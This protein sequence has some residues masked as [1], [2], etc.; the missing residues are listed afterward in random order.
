[1]DDDQ[2]RRYELVHLSYEKGVSSASWVYGVS[3]QNIYKWRRRYKEQGIEGLKT[4]SRAHKSY[5]NKISITERAE[6]IKFIKLNPNMTF[7]Q[8]KEG[9]KAKGI[10]RHWMTIYKIA[11][12]EGYPKKELKKDKYQLV[13]GTKPIPGDVRETE[14]TKATKGISQKEKIKKQKGEVQVQFMNW[15]DKNKYM[16]SK[17][18][19]KKV[20]YRKINFSSLSHEV[21]DYAEQLINEEFEKYE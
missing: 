8:M 16:H 21:K 20:F 12:E 7:K 14:G 10:D 13:I 4:L 9:L 1:M 17:R 15:F 5:P 11:C 6:I 18:E 2:K 3:R 19:M